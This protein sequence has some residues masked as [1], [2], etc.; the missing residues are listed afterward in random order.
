MS[1]K[2]IKKKCLFIHF[3]L[4]MLDKFL[5][6]LPRI[7]F[8]ISMMHKGNAIQRARFPSIT[9]TY[10]WWRVWRTKRIDEMIS[11]L[12]FCMLFSF[13]LFFGCDPKKKRKETKYLMKSSRAF[14][15]AK[16]IRRQIVQYALHCSRVVWYIVMITIISIIFYSNAFR[17]NVSTKSILKLK[18]TLP[19]PLTFYLIFS[20]N[21]C[22]E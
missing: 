11:P 2:R 14:I 20:V 9:Y 15:A 1:K 5:K 19:F 21:F 8:S 3:I 7:F 4:H 12:Q 6:D 18:S 16:Q 13:V 10:I 17:L 22:I